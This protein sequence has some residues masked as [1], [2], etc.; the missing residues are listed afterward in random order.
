M[1]AEIYII[2]GRVIELLRPWA[3]CKNYKAGDKCIKLSAQLLV[4]TDPRYRS[5][6]TEYY[7]L[8]LDRLSFFYFDTTSSFLDWFSEI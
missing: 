1:S 5:Y 8:N 3:S 2:P 7:L 6:I 4:S